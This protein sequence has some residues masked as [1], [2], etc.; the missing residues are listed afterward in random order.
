MHGTNVEV[1][2]RPAQWCSQDALELL[3]VEDFQIFVPIRHSVL[4]AT[5]WMLEHSV[6]SQFLQQAIEVFFLV[7]EFGLF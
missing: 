3:S 5:E 7:A 6:P 1:V 2:L 4:N